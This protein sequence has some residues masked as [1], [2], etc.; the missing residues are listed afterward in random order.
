MQF[1]ARERITRD[2]ELTQ[3]YI[4]VALPK[5]KRQLVLSSRYHF[6]CACPRCSGRTKESFTVDLFLNADISGVPQAFWG[7]Q[8]QDQIK[9]AGKQREE[10]LNAKDP[11]QKSALLEKSLLLHK[12]H[13]HE[14]NVHLLE[15]ESE[16]FSHYVEMQAYGEAIAHGEAMEKYY[17]SVYTKNHPIKALHLFTLGDLRQEFLQKK[18]EKCIE[19][20]KEA[21]R[22]L[23]ITHGRCHPLVH[24][25]EM[26]LAP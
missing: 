5:A 20:W 7:Q 9:D 23:R 14:M 3:T 15:L 13:L 10:G 22:I 21:L 8:R 26:R 19:A 17:K 4:D 1:R 11:H 25:L 16:L 12:A 2:Q 6:N 18:G 24:Q